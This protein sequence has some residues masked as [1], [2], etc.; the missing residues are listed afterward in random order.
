MAGLWELPG[1]KVEPGE[2]PEQAL[3]RELHEEL[4]LETRTSCL[5]PLTFA[6]HA[7]SSFHLL[8]PVFAVRI[9]KGQVNPPDQCLV[10]WLRPP[11]MVKLPMPEADIPLISL[12]RDLI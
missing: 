5:T 3:V 6:S 4:R 2:T 9:W 12:L 11:E 7:Y 8:M 10:R 1:G